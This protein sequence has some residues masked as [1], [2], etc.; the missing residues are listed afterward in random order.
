MAYQRNGNGYQISI[1]SFFDQTKDFDS[2]Y[3]GLKVTA[4]AFSKARRKLPYQVIENLCAQTSLN[5]DT[6]LFK[7]FR[8]FALDGSGFCAP[9]TPEL[10]EHFNKHS[11]YGSSGYYPQGNLVAAVDVG[12]KTISHAMV[13]CLH[14]SEKKLTECLVQN[15]DQN[16]IF[17]LDRGLATQNIFEAIYERSQHFVARLKTG[18]TA[19]KAF[20]NFEQSLARETYIKLHNGVMLRLLKIKVPQEKK[21]IVVATTLPESLATRKDVSDLYRSRWEVET[22]FD[23]VKSLQKL[24]NFH[25]RDYNGV[26]QEIFIHFL[27][28]NLTAM[29]YGE[30]NDQS[31]GGQVNR[32]A[33]LTHFGQRLLGM[34]VLPINLI[35]G[36]LLKVLKEL[37]E[38]AETTRRMKRP[39]R[40]YP[41]MSK[42]PVNKW[43]EGKQRK[44]ELQRVNGLS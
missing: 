11:T 6:E 3:D 17:L 43:S 37:W 2:R 22:I 28:H 35:K 44:K 25:A 7:G 31:E 15:F 12:N 40:S 39:G 32:K 1:D 23:Y 18:K 27:L 24:E 36:R 21:S 33:M 20:Q 42:Q 26:M 38:I 16:T 30:E 34:F 19:L 8:V 29:T 10:N 9:D 4:Q 41:R 13:D 5:Q 14:G